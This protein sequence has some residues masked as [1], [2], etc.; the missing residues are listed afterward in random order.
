MTDLPGE[1]ARREP[2][3]ESQIAL[4]AWLRALASDRLFLLARGEGNQVTPYCLEVD[5]SGVVCVF[6]APERAHAFGTRVGLTDEEARTML[7]IPVPECVEYLL[8]FGE[9]GVS[10]ALLDPGVTDAGVILA[11]L[12][13]LRRMALEQAA[14]PTL[15]QPADVSF[16]QLLDP[17]TGYDSDG[18]GR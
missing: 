11:A 4:A 8:Q 5:G 15:R 16:E 9:D 6:T 18:T 14:E 12:P 17:M 2:S 3:H 10:S 1:S 7:A 13:H